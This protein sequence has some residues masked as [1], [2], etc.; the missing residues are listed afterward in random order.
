MKKI[1]SNPGSV[2]KDAKQRLSFPDFLMMEHAAQGMADFIVKNY[3]SVQKILVLTGKGNNGADGFALVRLLLEK[4][5]SDFYIFT[6]DSPA[7]SEGKVQFDM[8]RKLSESYPIDF[9]DEQKLFNLLKIKTN[10][11]LLIID[12]IFGTGFKGELSEDVKKI[13]CQVNKTECHKLS[14]D[15]PSGLHA[16]GTLCREAFCTDVTLTMGC[17]KLCFYSDCAKSCTGKIITLNLGIPDSAFFGNNE[18]IACKIEKNDIKLPYRKKSDV[19]KGKFGHTAV[20]S[21]DKGGAC[22]LS[23]EAAFYSGSGLTSI[24]ESAESEL[25]KFKISPHLMLSKILPKKTTCI[26]SGP[27]LVSYKSDVDKIIQQYFNNEDKRH[28]AVFDAGCFDR[29]ELIEKIEQYS[30]R[31]ENEIVLTPHLYELSRFCKLVK[32]I[33]PDAG[34]TEDDINVE[35]LSNSCETKIKVGKALN[36]IFPNAALVMKSAYTFIAYREKI[37][38]VT[39]G[40]QN[41]AKGGSGDVLAGITGSL[42]AQGYNALEASVTACE[43]H[44]LASLKYGPQEFDFSPEKLIQ[45]IKEEFK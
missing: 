20:F 41:L 24:I 21:G 39:D 25:S 1:F 35:K 31:E 44:A 45:I 10:E 6:F 23:A 28:A 36:K 34:Y 30:N 43:A 7:T 14:C 8:C 19:H 38:I 17:D 9:I 2:E 4:Q 3:P 11:E 27:G 33:H 16:D 37:Y 29:K 5:K 26:V 42:L 40:A 12:C 32:E 22:I 13:L 15:V 18:E